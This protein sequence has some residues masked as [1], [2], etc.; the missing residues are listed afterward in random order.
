MGMGDGSGLDPDAI[1]DSVN[2]LANQLGQGFREVRY[3]NT[4]HG[5]FEQRQSRPRIAR[6][7]VAPGIHQPAGYFDIQWWKNGDYKYH[8]REQGL[9]FRFGR[10]AA[11]SG[12]NTPIRHFHPPN[13]LTTHEPSCIETGPPE[14]VT[15]AV[16]ATWWAAV[17][18]GDEGVLNTQNRLP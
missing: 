1:L 12:T 2:V 17:K 14:R 9:E 11:N 4:R 7:T 3:K 10:E 6:V 5:Q 13:D 18:A 8:Y 16:L 15:L